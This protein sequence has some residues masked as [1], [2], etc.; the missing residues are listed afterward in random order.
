MILNWIRRL[1]WKPKGK[2]YSL[3]CNQCGKGFLSS[4]SMEAPI[5]GYCLQKIKAP[6][7]TVNYGKK[8]SI[9]GQKGTIDTSDK[10]SVCF[11]K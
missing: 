9:C 8:C 11:N 7:N 3:K 5:C 10:C 2:M 1:T 6:K 4:Y